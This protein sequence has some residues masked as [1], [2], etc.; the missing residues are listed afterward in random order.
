ML[1][2]CL[3]TTEEFSSLFSDHSVLEAMLRFEAALARSQARL[4]MIPQS[5]ADA[6]SAVAPDQFDAAA[7]AREARG[8]ATVVIPFVR[9][10]TTHS[11][12]FAH[13]GATSQDVIDTA[14]VLLLARAKEI[15]RRDHHRLRTALR[16]LS[17]QHK[18]TVMLARTL[19][20]PAS[21]VTFG[22]KAALWYGGVAR[23]WRSLSQSFDEALLLQFG[24]ASGTLAAYGDR[25]PVLAEDL[26]KELHLGFAPPWHTQR[27]RLAA[28]VAN[29]GIYTGSLGKIARDV[30]LLMQFEVG[31]VSEAG[32]GSSAMP[33][34]RN[35]SLSA[36]ALAT[37]ARVPGLVGAYLAAM[38]QE[39]E[40]AA[41]P[42]QSEW[43]TI[44]E[45]VC[46]TGSALDAMTRS[47]ETLEVFPERMRAN[48]D[49]TGGAVL[50]E[51]AAMLLATQLGRDP[52]Q[53]KVAE[54]VEKAR[55]GP[56]RLEEI[57]NIELGSAEDYLG[58][59]E[60]F[61]R[62]LLDDAE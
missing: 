38:V 33:H 28:L 19:M 59:S 18:D 47:I 2:D 34:K 12:D 24:G 16:T 41:G 45:V 4:R 31:E 57:L 13:W 32:G 50:S 17:D 58:S 27:D 39:H 7:I 3:G 6:I 37:T 20:Q 1:I 35:P 9:A 48:L 29:L 46:A 43:Q 49:A 54:A 5:A 10:L 52:A 53:H 21:P 55:Q 8:S 11:S 36:I 56:R 61:R 22:Y 15:L 51:K 14:L 25:G 60:I 62:K 30:T 40:R 44:A 23:S 26:A 42:W